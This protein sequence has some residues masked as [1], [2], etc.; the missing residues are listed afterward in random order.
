MKY[1]I[2]ILMPALNEEKN[3]QRAIQLVLDSFSILNIQG[4]IVVI[5]DGSRDKTELKVK[6][7]QR[8]HSN[9]KLVS[10]PK[11]QGVGASYWTGLK[12]A[13]GELITWM[14]GDGETDCYETLR[15]LPL[16]QHVDIVIPFIYNRNVRSFWRKQISK[17]YKLIIN[18][19]FGT[20]LNYMNGATIYRKCVLDQ[21]DL[22]TKGFFFQVELLMKSIQLGYLYAEV[23]CALRQRIS[24][25]SKAL[26]LQSFLNV[27]RDY[28]ITTVAIYK[29]KNILEGQ[30]LHPDSVTARRRNDLEL[31]PEV[32][33][34]RVKPRS[35]EKFH[36]AH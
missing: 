26:T 12:V 1:K 30:K 25:K 34:V 19:T 14:P 13:E 23:P 7:M 35:T 21:I 4:E 31:K 15:Y 20:L 18:L 27:V 6:A 3:I 5:N 2:S 32:S 24:G 22:K 9:I 36:E 8:I 10:H 29:T 16:L 11:N 33:P 28:I 17:A